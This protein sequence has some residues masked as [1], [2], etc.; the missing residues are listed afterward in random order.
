MNSMLEKLQPW[1]GSEGGIQICLPNKSQDAIQTNPQNKSQDEVLEHIRESKSYRSLWTIHGSQASKNTIQLAIWQ[2]VGLWLMVIMIAN[3]AMY[4]GFT[5]G[6]Q[7]ADG[8]PRIAV[9]LIYAVFYICHSIFMFYCIF[10]AYTVAVYSACWTLL[11]YAGFTIKGNLDSNNVPESRQTDPSTGSST[12]I[13]PPDLQANEGTSEGKGNLDSNNALE[14]WEIDR[15]IG[16]YTFT[17]KIPLPGGQ[18]NRGTD[19]GK[20]GGKPS[21]DERQ[22]SITEVHDKQK[23]EE[24]E[25]EKATKAALDHVLVNTTILLSISVATSFSTWTPRQQSDS[26]STQLGSLALLASAS[27]ALGALLGSALQA[28]HIRHHAEKILKMKEIII[29]GKAKKYRKGELDDRDR[30]TMVGFTERFGVKPVRHRIWPHHLLCA[31]K[32]HHIIFG[33]FLGPAFVLIPSRKGSPSERSKIQLNLDVTGKRYDL[34]REPKSDTYELWDVTNGKPRIFVNSIKSGS[35]GV[36][37][38]PTDIADINHQNTGSIIERMLP[39]R[40]E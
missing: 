8:W 22:K 34:M 32:P 9:V 26:T 4:N 23:K 24:E 37:T 20:G 14:N 1:D 7:N 31:L 11:G 2:W 19:E 3:T 33:L 39:T 21:V 35:A 25:V 17:P 27:S 38:K 18:A 15:S 16:S 28:S 29:N 30:E 12:S 40:L 6:E 5:S 36:V 13:P 10:G